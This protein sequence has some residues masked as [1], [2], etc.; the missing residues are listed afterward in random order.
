[1][2]EDKLQGVQEPDRS[3]H[4]P[5]KK[6]EKELLFGKFVENVTAKTASPHRHTQKACIKRI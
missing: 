3:K 1:M 2:Q 4:S 6:E 5:Q